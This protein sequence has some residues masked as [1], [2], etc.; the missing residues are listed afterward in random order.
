MRCYNCGTELGDVA[1]LS[2]CPN[3]G[4]NLDKPKDF[5]NQE[6]AIP[7]YEA[8]PNG[9]YYQSVDKEE[10]AVKTDVAQPAVEEPKKKKLNPLVIILPILGVV[11]AGAAAV[12]LFVLPGLKGEA[13]E[14]SRN[15]N[16]S[17]VE[18]EEPEVKPEETPEPTAEPVQE[19]ADGELPI[20]PM[21]F[22]DEVFFYIDHASD[23]TM[24][25]AISEQDIVNN[26]MLW[27]GYAYVGLKDFTMSTA[28]YSVLA[29]R[30][31]EFMIYK[32]DLS[33]NMAE[34]YKTV[35]PVYTFGMLGNSREFADSTF[36]FMG[37][38]YDNP[39]DNPFYDANL[40]KQ[41]Q[42]YKNLVDTYGEELANEYFA[43][44]QK[45][46]SSSF[47]VF[48]SLGTTDPS[49]SD[50]YITSYGGMYITDLDANGDGTMTIVDVY[51]D[52]ETFE[53]N[54]ENPDHW[55][56]YDIDMSDDWNSYTMSYK[57]IAS[58]KLFK[59]SDN[60]LMGFAA[61]DSNAYN[62]IAG[63]YIADSDFYTPYTDGRDEEDEYINSY[64]QF[65]M[66]IMTDGTV[67]VDPVIT[68]GDDNMLSVSFEKVY[69][70]AYGTEEDNPVSF[71]ARYS[72]IGYGDGTNGGFA[73][74]DSSGTYYYN[75]N[76]DSYVTD[77]LGEEYLDLDFVDILAIITIN[78]R[79]GNEL[80]N[81]LEAAGINA[82]LDPNTGNLILDNA[83][84]FAVDKSNLSSDGK[85][86]LDAVADVYASV[87]LSETY[88]GR[89]G[90]I[91][92]D[93]YADPAGD[94]D[95]NM[96][97]SEARAKSVMD[98]IAGRYSEMGDILVSAGHSSDNP[99]LAEDGTVDYA[100]SRRVEIAFVISMDDYIA[101][102]SPEAVA[103]YGTYIGEQYGSKLELR[104]GGR[105]SFTNAGTTEPV[106]LTWYIDGDTIVIDAGYGYELYADY[107]LD[108]L[109]LYNDS[110]SSW[111]PDTF[112]RIE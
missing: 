96:T 108:E 66:I 80:L 49:F 19:L 10:K 86:Y 50:G 16:H 105:G 79:I 84:M 43:N 90:A 112:D 39:Q 21:N 56:T 52:P 20:G 25:E 100:A 107:D 34:E 67:A 104:S 1:G 69:N 88:A 33:W 31:L 91:K 22:T 87:V 41:R 40:G 5:E 83:V 102:D 106:D 9:P 85:A 73:L 68:F 89:I 51:I 82:T 28:D 78:S 58:I 8:D 60:Y 24:D 45:I 103:L 54:L 23:T 14:S 81:G 12:V 62:D 95:Y 38:D 27:G 109:Y 101:E 32:Q 63:F 55:V 75:Y 71:T 26:N 7:E 61:N 44:Y 36:A 110:A 65:P 42:V 53:M 111:H 17:R 76:A 92:V 4:V 93:G 47:V 70:L 35:L 3:C 30:A 99:I 64:A 18:V 59:T 37:I 97:L 77:K 29:D 2:F 46:L 74:T 15:S 48:N 6:N 11:L 57:D 72:L 13:E 98:Y 94:Y